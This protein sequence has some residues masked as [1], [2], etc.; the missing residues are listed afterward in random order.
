MQRVSECKSMHDIACYALPPLCPPRLWLA[1]KW[2]AY[3]VLLGSEKL[4]L[5]VLW[6]SL[7]PDS[8][9]PSH[10]FA[11]QSMTRNYYLKIKLNEEMGMKRRRCGG[12]EK[13][14]GMD[15]E[16]MERGREE[17][18]RRGKEGGEE[19]DKNRKIWETKKRWRGTRRQEED[20]GSVG[21]VWASHIVPWKTKKLI[22][23]CSRW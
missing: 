13:R 21:H 4:S 20:S 15:T 23:V 6:A 22:C 2:P 19:E 18:K 17:D 1:Y 7:A 14:R 8:M 3:T 9:V 12:Q 10:I 5:W 11:G 16:E